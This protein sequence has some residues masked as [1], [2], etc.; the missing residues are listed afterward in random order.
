MRRR[1]WTPGLFMAAWGGLDP[2]AAQVADLSRATCTQLLEL[3]PRDREQFVL[4]LHGY[5]AGAAQRP[6]IDRAKLEAIADA[7]QQACD[8][9]RTLPLIGPEARGLFLGDPAPPPPQPTGAAPSAPPPSP[10]IPT[11]IR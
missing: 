4:W 1:W 6:V 5:Y 8:R 9:D 2:A 10:A 3:P 7:M 11:P